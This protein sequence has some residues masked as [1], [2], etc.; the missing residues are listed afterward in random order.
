MS[1]LSQMYSVFREHS[2]TAATF[3]R[4]HEEKQVYRRHT[5]YCVGDVA[6]TSSRRLRAAFNPADFWLHSFTTDYLVNFLWDFD[7]SI[8]TRS[9]K[10]TLTGGLSWNLSV[11]YDWLHGYFVHFFSTSITTTT[12][13]SLS[14]SR[15]RILRVTIDGERRR[16]WHPTSDYPEYGEGPWPA[17]LYTGGVT[18]YEEN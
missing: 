4:S 1:T 2:S 18:L 12:H 9:G 3:H 5:K 15:S 7:D 6:L 17:T 13:H 11:D 16:N 14:T 10:D 8:L